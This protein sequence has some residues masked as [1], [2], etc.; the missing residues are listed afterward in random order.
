MFRHDQPWVRIQFRGACS[1][2]ETI[3][4][5]VA[6]AATHCSPEWITRWAAG[7]QIGRTRITHPRSGFRVEPPPD[8]SVDSLGQALDRLLS[9]VG[10]LMREVL[11][12]AS[13]AD[14]DYKL[15]VIVYIIGTAAPDL[16]MS[17]EH[18]KLIAELG[19]QVSFDLSVM[20]E[21]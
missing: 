3:A 17:A 8:E 4:G 2:N 5:V 21:S 6:Q 20:S 12:D 13:A 15:H 7:D 16:S 11:G 19:V 1:R 18:L 10:G 9:E 14:V